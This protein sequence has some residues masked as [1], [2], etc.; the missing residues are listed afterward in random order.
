MACLVK[1][2]PISSDESVKYV[3]ANS[4]AIVF[5]SGIS[6]IFRQ[7]KQGNWDWKGSFN[8]GIPGAIASFGM[9]YLIENGHW[10]S[11]SS[12]QTIFLGF[13]LISIYNML[14][15][16]KGQVTDQTTEVTFQP[17]WKKWTI[18]LIAGTTVSL[19]GLGGGV[20]MVP[21]FRML[22]K[23]PMKKA[24]ALSLSIVPIL[25]FASL[26]KYTNAIP[27]ALINKGVFEVINRSRL[28]RHQNR[29]GLSSS[30]ATSRQPLATPPINMV[31]STI[32][33]DRLTVPTV[34]AFVNHL[35]GSQPKEG[36]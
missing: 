13:L 30:S 15:S 16:K 25:A 12:F 10:Y 26:L 27:Y 5:A 17:N 32:V 9:S 34:E 33:L 20:I 31:M 6:G 4:I 24:T 23:M 2:H 14:F 18:G 36:Q 3:L 21:L 1:S 22:L 11:K 7:Y 29:S 35:N 19:S 8:I 28:T